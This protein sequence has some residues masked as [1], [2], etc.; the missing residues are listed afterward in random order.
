MEIFASNYNEVKEIQH[1]NLME[2]CI[3]D[4]PVNTRVLFDRNGTPFTVG[5]LQPALSCIA[6][7]GRDVS[8]LTTRPTH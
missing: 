7:N 6:P 5:T 1:T 3:V 4:H 8:V 2:L